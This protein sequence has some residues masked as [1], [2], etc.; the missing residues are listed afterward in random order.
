M[1]LASAQSGA[2]WA[3]AQG[4]GRA[5]PSRAAAQPTRRWMPC[6]QAAYSR[7]EPIR[8]MWRNRPANRWDSA[9]PAVQPAM[10]GPDVDPV[11]SKMSS[12]PPLEDPTDPDGPAPA[13]AR[14]NGSE[15]GRGTPIKAL[16][17]WHRSTNVKNTIIA[18]LRLFAT[19]LPHDNFFLQI[20]LDLGFQPGLRSTMG[21]Y[22]GRDVAEPRSLGRVYFSGADPLGQSRRV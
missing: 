12:G 18:G 19:P 20:P 22:L 10:P 2:S 9:V 7:A 5:Q 16:S 21:R 4:H 6:E 13:P 8:S 14:A 15:R 11:C 1:A 3:A 17:I